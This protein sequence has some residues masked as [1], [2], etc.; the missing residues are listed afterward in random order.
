MRLVTERHSRID[1]SISEKM[2]KTVQLFLTV[3]LVLFTAQ[4]VFAQATTTITTAGGDQYQIDFLGTT[5]AGL[6]WN[7]K[8]T[9]LS[10]K[11]LS[12]WTLGLCVDLQE[13]VD[14]SPKEGDNNG[15]I[16][17]VELGLDPTTGVTGIKWNTGGDYDGDGDEGGDMFEFSFTLANVYPVQPT[18]VAAKTQTEGTSTIDGPGCDFDICEVTPAPMWDGEFFDV[19]GGFASFTITSDAGIKQIYLTDADNAEIAGVDPMIFDNVD[20]VVTLKDG[21]DAPNEITVIL[22]APEQRSSFFFANIVDCCDRTV[23]VDPNLNLYEGSE[24]V[25]VAT[26]SQNYPNPFNPETSIGFELS[27]SAVVSLKVYN[28][29]GQLIRTLAAGQFEAGAHAV[30]WNGRDD[31]GVTAPSGVYLYKLEAGDFS[32]TKQLLLLK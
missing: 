12:H 31:A 13:V 20:G 8:V 15:G 18:P 17:Q 21:E 7:Y 32:Q 11:D 4:G 6:T 29:M 27:N 23:V 24:V 19:G 26:L 5:D 30:T 16:G 14:W 3:A 2:K 25:E 9:E 10:G 28:V 22:S 1:I